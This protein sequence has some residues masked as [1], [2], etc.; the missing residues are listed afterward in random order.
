LCLYALGSML[1]NGLSVGLSSDFPVADPN[2]LVGICAA[3][4]RMTTTGSRIAPQQGIS[5]ESA[6]NGYTLGAAAASFEDGI[7]GSITPGKL[8]DLVIL[9]K[10]PNSVPPES[11]KDIEVTMTILDGRIVW[12]KEN[13]AFIE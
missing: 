9:N 7:K 12:E 8:A 4:T 3:V 13:S 1:G 2:P 11:I 6:I 10:D 5:V